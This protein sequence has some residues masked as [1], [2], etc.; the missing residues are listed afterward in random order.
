MALMPRWAVVA[1]FLCLVAC[2]KGDA[3]MGPEPATSDPAPTLPPPSAGQ[4]A[5]APPSAHDPGPAVAFVPASFAPIARRADP[6]VVTINTVTDEEPSAFLPGRRRLRRTVTGLGTGFLF[7]KDGLILTNNHVVEGADT[8]LVKLF[9]DKAYPARV[10]GR[11]SR[12]DIAVV[13]IEEH[14]LPTLGLGDS[15]AIEVGDW[16]VAIGNPFNLSHTVSAGILSA[17]G[18]THDDVPLPDPTGYYNF[19]QTDASINPGNSGGPLLDMKGEV[20]GINTAIRDKAQGLSFAIPINMVKQLLPM[21]LRDGHVTRSALG[22]S[23]KDVRSLSPEDRED[24]KV[25]SDHGAFVAGVTPG[26]PADKAHVV[27]GDIIL[28]FDGTVIEHGTVL[29]WLA[30]TA[31]VGRTVDLRVLREGKQLDFKVK[32]GQLAESTRPEPPGSDPDNDAFGRR[33]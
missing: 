22:I 12:T 23:V 19:L 15:D 18:R 21:L 27:F 5:A 24:F 2:K 31:G 1:V 4:P 13:K 20:V 14:G 9:N 10:I 32:L 28:A 29:P 26:G 30:S 25:T 11:D 6:S 7:D 17:K 3:S 8:I 33:H 16:V